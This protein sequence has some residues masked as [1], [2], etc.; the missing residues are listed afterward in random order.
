MHLD[1]IIVRRFGE[2]DDKAKSARA[3]QFFERQGKTAKAGS[4]GKASAH[5]RHALD[6]R[7]HRLAGRDAQAAGREL[8]DA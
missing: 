4:N 2:L 5:H 7:K 8:A 6:L 1:P 3:A